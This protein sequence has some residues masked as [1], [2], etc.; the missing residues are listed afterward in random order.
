MKRQRSLTE[1]TYVCR[2]ND[3]APKN[4]IAL[5]SQSLA[6][7]YNVY[8][9]SAFLPQNM[10]EVSPDGGFYLEAYFLSRSLPS[11]FFL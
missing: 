11:S 7:A 9:V 2:F 4:I 3:Q 6:A 10:Q 1:T 5:A 8:T